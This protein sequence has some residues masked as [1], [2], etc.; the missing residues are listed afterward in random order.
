MTEAIAEE[1]CNS[2]PSLGKKSKSSS[3][4]S[5]AYVMPVEMILCSHMVSSLAHLPLYMRL[6][7]GQFLPIILHSGSGL[8]DTEFLQVSSDKQQHMYPS[9]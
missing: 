8:K 9:H 7:H 5:L 6:K 3:D 2:F 1:E 4:F